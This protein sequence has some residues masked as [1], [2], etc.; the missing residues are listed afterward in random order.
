MATVVSR[1]SAAESPQ[2][3]NN[4]ETSAYLYTCNACQ[5]AFRNRELQRGH[6][7]SDWQ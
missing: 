6:M 2:T 3:A 5:V 7:H 1:R 4:N